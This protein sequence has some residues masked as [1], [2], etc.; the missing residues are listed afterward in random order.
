MGVIMLKARAIVSMVELYPNV[1]IGE[2]YNSMIVTSRP[3]EETTMTVS[4][5][6]IRATVVAIATM[7]TITLVTM[8]TITRAITQT[9]AASPIMM[10][11]RIEDT[12]INTPMVSKETIIIE[13]IGIKS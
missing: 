8:V 11:M 13:A 3:Q 10:I 4:S 1:T 6:K 5:M 9:K 7:G 2:E 12:G